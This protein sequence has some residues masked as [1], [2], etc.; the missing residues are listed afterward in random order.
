[1]NTFEHFKFF[2]SSVEKKHFEIRNPFNKK[3]LI[4]VACIINIF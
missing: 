4:S 1:M 3:I 2:F